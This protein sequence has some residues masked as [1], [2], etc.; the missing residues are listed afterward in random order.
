MLVRRRFNRKRKRNF[1][2]AELIE[3]VG[4]DLVFVYF[5]RLGGIGRRIFGYKNGFKFVRKFGRGYYF[6]SVIHGGGEKITRYRK[7]AKTYDN[8]VENI[9]QKSR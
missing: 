5:A 2:F 6:R 9:R 3:Y 8:R 1:V 7:S 4:D